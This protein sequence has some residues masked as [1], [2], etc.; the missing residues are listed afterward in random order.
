MTFQHLVM[1]SVG[2]DSPEEHER[3]F[4][5][6]SEL[7]RDL[8]RGYSYT[9]LTSQAV[10]ETGDEDDEDGCDQEHLHHDDHTLDKVRQAFLE[11]GV[12]PESVEDLINDLHN[13]GL[14]FRER[15]SD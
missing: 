6:F 2:T 3:V 1:L 13:A 4:G 12:S 10:D 15:I 9:N 14:L 7:H 11:H 8:A 5:D